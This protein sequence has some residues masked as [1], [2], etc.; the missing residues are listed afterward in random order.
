MNLDTHNAGDVVAGQRRGGELDPE[1]IAAACHGDAAE[2]ERLLANGADATACDGTGCGILL[3]VAR[4][5]AQPAHLDILQMLLMAGANPNQHHNGGSALIHVASIGRED[6]EALRERCAALLIRYGA[7]TTHANNDGVTA[8]HMAARSGHAGMVRR[9]LAAGAGVDAE[10]FDGATPLNLMV[11]VADEW[12][13]ER[14]QETARVLLDAGADANH[15]GRDGLS[16]WLQAAERGDV[17]MLD[18]L[19]AHGADILQC[20]ARGC[21]ALWYS[22]GNRAMERLCRMGVRPPTSGKARR[23]FIKHL[24]YKSPDGN[25]CLALCEALDRTS[26]QH[27]ALLAPGAASAAWRKTRRRS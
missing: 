5:L 12:S 8:L 26:A 11:R 23:D 2:V 16:A 1:L 6:D 27:Q 20:D 19:Q 24:R 22:A 15:A 14:R 13:V 21:N 25:A 17:P 10:M 7:R 18:L 3:H 9:L 4:V